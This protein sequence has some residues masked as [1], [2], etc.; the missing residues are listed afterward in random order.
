[1]YGFHQGYI[2]RIET[3]SMIKLYRLK[4]AYD[5]DHDEINGG[6]QHEIYG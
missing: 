1:M 3:L 6:A 5:K 2:G 4:W